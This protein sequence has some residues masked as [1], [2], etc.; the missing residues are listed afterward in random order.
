MKPTDYKLLTEL[1]QNDI[2][3]VCPIPIITTHNLITS[4]FE[5]VDGIAKL[6]VDDQ[7]SFYS[8]NN[9]LRIDLNNIVLLSNTNYNSKALREEVEA[10][11]RRY[12]EYRKLSRSNSTGF[13]AFAGLSY[14]GYASDELRHEL[15]L[16]GQLRRE[17][18]EAAQIKGTIKIST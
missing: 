1:N 10:S 16:E 5:R 17:I 4:N 11:E 3:L 12:E 6:E 2:A 13:S 18:S 8:N 9:R 7:F 15:D 14:S